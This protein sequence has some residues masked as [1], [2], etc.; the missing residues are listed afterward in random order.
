MILDGNIQSTMNQVNFLYLVFFKITHC[1]LRYIEK[2]S[3]R[4]TVTTVKYCIYHVQL[5]RII[6]FS[7]LVIY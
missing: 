4:F 6:P 2:N 5:P 3:I 7:T 1:Y